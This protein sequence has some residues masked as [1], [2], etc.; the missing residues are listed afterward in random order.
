MNIYK[1][2]LGSM[3]TEIQIHKNWKPLCIQFQ[4]GIP[5]LWAKVDT[6]QEKIKAIIYQIG[7]GWAVD[8]SNI[9][10]STIQDGPYVWHYFY[11]SEDE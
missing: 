2:E 7:T 10:I 8:N 11:K 6:E 1:Y 9:Y 3:D 5:T 4:N